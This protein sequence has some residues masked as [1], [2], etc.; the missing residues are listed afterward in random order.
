MDVDPVAI[1][2]RIKALQVEWAVDA[3]RN[4]DKDYPAF[5]QGQTTGRQGAAD[6]IVGLIENLIKEEEEDDA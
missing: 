1:I 2:A 3:A 5:H 4:P 6:E